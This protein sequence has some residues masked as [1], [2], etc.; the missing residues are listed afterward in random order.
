[1]TDD[2]VKPS[3]NDDST[4]TSLISRVR[5]NDQ[6]A[7]ARLVQ[8]YSALVY[9]WCAR[10]G[11]Q[12]ADIDDIC[13]DVF[14]SVHRGLPNFRK[15]QPGDSFRAWLR[16]ITMNRI[17]DKVGKRPIIGE[18]G[19][20]AAAMIAEIPNPDNPASDDNEMELSILFRRLMGII[21][22]EFEETSWQAFWRMVIEEQP[23]SAVAA[24]LGMT[25]NAMYLAKSRILRRLRI[26]LEELGENIP[27]WVKPH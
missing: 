1:V 23:V 2:D 10:C 14:R 7:W 22:Q 5:R 4:S 19:S 15:E 20:S 25:P 26:V 27:P 3:G 24:D 9:R 6:S 12:P 13:Q 8:L 17:R 16:T 11:F 18:G 21:R